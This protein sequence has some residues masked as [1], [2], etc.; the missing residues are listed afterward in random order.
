MV[1]LLIGVVLTL[2]S[3]ATFAT[4][5]RNATEVKANCAASCDSHGQQVTATNQATK[6]DE[7]DLEP[8]PPA[9]SWPQLPVSLLLLYVMP[10]FAVL[11]FISNKR[12][13][14]LS[15]QLRI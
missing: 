14:L 15:T 9:I 10:I 12:K 8:T 11:W 6:E 7:D 3:M 2:C 13:L 1:A 5:A 4:H